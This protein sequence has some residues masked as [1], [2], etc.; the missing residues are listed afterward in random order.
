MS[1]KR[2]GLLIALIRKNSGIKQGD[3]AKSLEITQP[4]LSQVEK[5][6]KEPSNTLLQKIS[7]KLE[8]PA[9]FIHLLSIEKEEVREDRRMAWEMLTP[10]IKQL[11]ISIFP[12][13]LQSA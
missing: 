2:I 8:V 3:F 13:K 6:I 9:A 10:V 12:E 5:G 4:Y 7:E 1:K 11:C